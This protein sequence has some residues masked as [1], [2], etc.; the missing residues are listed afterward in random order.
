MNVIHC[1]Y[2]NHADSQSGIKRYETELYNHMKDKVELDRF[3]RTKR[4]YLL[5]D[6]NLNGYDIVHATFQDM[7]P[8]KILKHVDNFVLTVHDIIPKLYYSIPQKI[9]HMWYLTECAIPK[10]DRIITDSV[11]TAQTLVEHFDINL[12]KINVVPLGVSDKY[13]LHC[14]VN[15]LD[16][17]GLPDKNKYIL[18]NSSNEP[19]KNVFTADQII[20]QMPQYKF[21]KI[22]Y[23]TTIEADN[24]INL[25]F[26]PESEMPYLYS[27]C[28]VFLHTSEYEGFGLP[29][30]EAMACGCPV[31]SSNASSLPE[32]VGSGGILVDTMDVEAY[33]D[34]IYGIT[35]SISAHDAIREAGLIQADT[36]TWEKTAEQ[37]LEVYKSCLKE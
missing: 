8:L 13:H 24:V 37:T 32:V 36:F 27:A 18:I 14:K 25:G 29:V 15:S 3:Q 10:A 4:I 30:L 19:W 20:K 9:K 2:F 35:S 12:D 33:C 11:Y 26:V 34:A 5:D 17:I 28:D 31:V 6:F 7:A 22:G 21:V 23:G 16:R 1:N